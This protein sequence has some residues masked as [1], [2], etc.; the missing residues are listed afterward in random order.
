MSKLRK[1]LPFWVA[2]IPKAQ[3][4]ATG[5]YEIAPTPIPILSRYV[6][7]LTSAKEFRE[8]RTSVAASCHT[9]IRGTHL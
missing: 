2:V 5:A 3:S 4:R 6:A 1:P 8:A 9:A 7:L